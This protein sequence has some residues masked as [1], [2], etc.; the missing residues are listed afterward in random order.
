MATS[1]FEITFEGAAD[2]D[3]FDGEG[4]QMVFHVTNRF[5][6]FRNVAFRIAVM[7]DFGQEDPAAEERAWFEVQ[8]PTSLLQAGAGM[9]CTVK[10]TVPAGTGAR[11]IVW[12]LVAYDADLGDEPRFFSQPVSLDVKN[13]PVVVPEPV[14]EKKIPWWIWLVV[15]GAAVAVI[16]A[17]AIGVGSSQSND[18]PD[19]PAPPAQPAEET[20]AEAPPPQPEEHSYV[21]PATAKRRI[22]V[23]VFSAEDRLHKRPIEGA[24]VRVSVNIDGFSPREYQTNTKGQAD[25]MLCADEVGD[26]LLEELVDADETY[27]VQRLAEFDCQPTVFGLVFVAER[28]G[29]RPSVPLVATPDELAVEGQWAM[30]PMMPIGQARAGLPQSQLV[31]HPDEFEHRLVDSDRQPSSWGE[32][33]QPWDRNQ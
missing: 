17:I 18:E 10:A 1:C 27:L 32:R 13:R 15:G 23:R 28:A 29:Y 16:V 2:L 25:V 31:P 24:T 5:T 7:N 3:L 14:V 21:A 11:K 6:E 9:Q 22:P 20:A 12:G 4:A 26:K 30:L 19:D 33:E 8:T